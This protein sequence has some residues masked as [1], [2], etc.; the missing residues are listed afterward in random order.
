MQFVPV[1]IATNVSMAT[2]SNSIGIDCNQLA[3]AS[4]QASWTGTA[5]AGTFKLQISDDIVPVAASS[6][7]PVG[8]DPAANVVNWSDY[9]G[10]STVV[11]GDGNFT[12]NMVYVGFRWVRL[13]YTAAS[14]TGT[15]NATF[16][17]KG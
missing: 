11:A 10:S 8:S 6:S 15:Y 17:G 12:W 4:I 3:L 16:S 1:R 2:S 5:E 9:T 13:V 7:N 14:G